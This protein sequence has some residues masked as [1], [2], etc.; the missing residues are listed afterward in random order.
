MTAAVHR[1]L[2]RIIV[3]LV[4]LLLGASRSR[5][6]PD[7]SMPSLTLEEALAYARQHQPKISSALA[8]LAARTAEARIPRAKWLPR[9]AATAQLFYGTNNNSS[10]VSLGVA[11]V[12][13][14]RTGG[15]PS[16]T[17]DTARW[18]PKPSTLAAISVDQEV[19]DFGRIAAQSSVADALAQVAR[20]S[21]DAVAL[22]VGLAVE[23]TF[24]GV[25]AAKE[26]LRATDAAY[27]RT[28]THRDFARA[29]V[30]SGLRPPIDLTRA[31]ADLAQ[32][33]VRRV[34][35]LSGVETARAALAAAVGSDALEVD[36][37]PLGLDASEAPAFEEVLRAASAKNPFVLAA[38]AR[39]DAQRSTTRAL[40][41]ELLPNFF[42]SAGVSGRAGGATPSGGPASV[43]YGSGWLPDVPNW[44]VGL[45]LSWSLFDGALLARRS[46]SVAREG[47]ARADLELARTSIT[48]D[49]QRA[50]ID[51]DAA[52]KVLPGLG[53]AVVAAR[54]NQSQADARFRAGL[55]NVVEL[56]DAE[57][58]L[59]TS[60]LG[61]AVGQFTVAR[62][63]AALG[64]VMAEP[65]RAPPPASTGTGSV[66]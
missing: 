24:H 33:E 4:A 13:I 21:A 43:P 44:H 29:G 64:R 23:E 59:T 47:A 11:G 36:A 9:V 22:D 61:L 16:R 55:G 30:Q 38:L 15:T 35:A 62:A 19:Y 53:E 6:A 7:A 63:R 51:L 12:D 52:L 42:G 31:Q 56:A 54:A 39:L 41:R 57:G 28:E 37:Q 34:R 3:A 27:K 66:R 32:L 5:A 2:A 10:A 26:I 14:P 17:T 45:V 50:F 58:L 65:T 40:T 48:L 1:H 49:S 18:T 25:L 20:T 60:E 8:E 46:A